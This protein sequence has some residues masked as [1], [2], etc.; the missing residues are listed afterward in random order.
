MLRLCLGFVYKLKS[1]EDLDW[2]EKL[3]NRKRYNTSELYK[4]LKERVLFH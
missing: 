3:P 4:H 2:D 1:P